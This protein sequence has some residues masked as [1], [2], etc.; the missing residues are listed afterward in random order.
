[1]SEQEQ[2]QGEIFRIEPGEQLSRERNRLGISLQDASRRLRLTTT[3]LGKIERGELDGIPGAYLR[4]YVA[5]YARLL[6]M[7]PEPLLQ[8]LE[9]LDPEPLRTVLPVDRAGQR[10]DRFVRFATYGLVTTLIV[11]PLVYFFVQGG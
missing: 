7:D 5:N 9:Q 6:E 10:M 11:P 8:A 3:V 1:M 4:G 2:S